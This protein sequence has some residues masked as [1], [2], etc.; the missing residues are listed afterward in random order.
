MKQFAS[1]VYFL[2]LVCLVLESVACWALVRRGYW[3]HWKAFGCYLFYMLVQN[4]AL[5]PVALWGSRNA[6]VITYD[7][8]DFVEVVLLSLVVLEILVKVL[9]PVEVLPAR[10]VAQACFWAALGISIAVALSVF[11]RGSGMDPLIDLPLTIERTI[12]L[13]DSMLLWVLLFQAKAFGITWK[14]SMAEIAIGFVLYLTVQATAR[15]V[16]SLYPNGP[17]ANIAS[18]VGQVAYIIALS[19]WI[20]TITHRDPQ[21]V[22]ASA[23]TLTRMRELASDFDAVP[24]ERIFA[25]VGIRVNRT[26]QDDDPELEEQPPDKTR[27]YTLK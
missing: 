11:V 3:A 22:R 21:P 15:F 17:V 18:G 1:W 5:L 14:S 20:W 12:F 4:L 10:S 16:V 24:K 13:A 2:W 19:S 23:E 6:Y 26:D 9:E 7:I 27:R 8:A 25:A